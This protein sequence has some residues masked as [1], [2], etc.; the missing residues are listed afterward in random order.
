MTSKDHSLSPPDDE[1][2]TA[3]TGLL[4]PAA[5]QIYAS[6]VD[7]PDRPLSRDPASEELVAAGFA[8]FRYGGEE[9]FVLPPRVAMARALENATRRWIDA[10]PDFEGLA[11]AMSRVDG[12]RASRPATEGEVADWEARQEALESLIVGARQQVRV[13]QPWYPG[14][15][16]GPIDPDEWSSAPDVNT[17]R[18]VTFRFVYDDRLLRVPGFEDIIRHELELGAQVRI[19]NDRIPSFLTLIDDG[20]VAYSPVPGGPGE[21]STAAGLV[22]LLGWTFEAFWTR[23][24]PLDRSDE[25]SPTLQT[26]MAMVGLGRS[27]RQIAQTLGVH[28]R[29]VRRRVEDLLDHY[30]QPDRTALMRHAAAIGVRTADDHPPVD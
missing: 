1:L 20:A 6:L 17:P 10:A 27:N 29:T 16:D 14:Q 4:S 7:D 2:V 8:A 24:V 12:R 23:G 21:I 3:L 22:G 28:E 11:Q 13:L 25:L 30:G 19:T 15:D 18:D 9:A 5:A 26:V